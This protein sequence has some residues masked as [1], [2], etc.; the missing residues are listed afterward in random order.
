MM[1]I[2]THTRI[3]GVTKVPR[4]AILLNLLL[5]FERS[6]A[7]Y[8]SEYHKYMKHDEWLIIFFLICG[9]YFQRSRGIS[10]SKIIVTEQ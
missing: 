8:I 2:S 5:R 1:L 4:V 3:I 7:S 9:S 6:Y 10:V